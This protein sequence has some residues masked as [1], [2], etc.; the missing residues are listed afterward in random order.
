MVT[1]VVRVPFKVECRRPSRPSTID[2]P[3]L[4]ITYL[5]HTANGGV[6]S[7]CWVGLVR[8]LSGPLEVG[9]APRLG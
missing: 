7:E 6:V 1:L 5:P 8:K 4:P 3:N 9:R 2:S